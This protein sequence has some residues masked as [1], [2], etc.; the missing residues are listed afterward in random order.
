LDSEIAKTGEVTVEGHVLGRLEGFRFVADPAAGGS[1]AKA[2][3]AAA[4]KA[5]AGEMDARANRLSQAGDDQFIL[6]SDGLI[7]WQGDAVGALAAGEEILR[8]RVRILA[9]EQ[10]TGASRDAVQARLDLW[11]KAHIEK[12]LGPLLALTAAEDITGIARGVAFQLVEALGVLERQKVAEDVKGLDQPAR[13]TLRKYGVR[14]GAY[15]IY[16]PALLKPA[17]RALAVQLYALKQADGETNG[18]GEV[19]QLASSGRTSIA[20]NKEISGPLYRPAGYRVCGE[21][22]VRVD[23]L[24]RLADLIRPALAWRE[25]APG[26]KPAGAIDGFGFT[27]SVGMTSLVGSSG[28]DFA[29]ILR[30]LGY[31]MDRRPKPAEAASAAAAADGGAAADATAGAPAAAPAVGEAPSVA[32]DAGAAPSVAPDNGAAASA[33]IAPAEAAAIMGL[34]AEDAPATVPDEAAEPV[35]AATVEVSAAEASAAE[36]DASIAEGDN[37]PVAA[38]AASP[39][40]PTATPTTADREPEF[41][42]VWR[43]GRVDGRD[44]P[45]K[46]SARRARASVP[47]PAATAAATAPTDAPASA[48]PSEPAPKPERKSFGRHRRP[49]RRD[50]RPD[51][52]DARPDR[53]AERRARPEQREKQPDP[54]S[55]FAK[56]AALKAELEAKDR[57]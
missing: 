57:R 23:I 13:A 40:E 53:S 14:F 1:E 7:R 22:A 36:G 54:N 18:L 48:A 56:L 2:L 34:T 46:R 47:Q 21:R 20:V 5:L 33:D 50:N 41:I 4:Q 25:G 31:R 26:V 51:R 43:P 32:P 35:A 42:E 10:L 52:R 19:Q 11:I 8:P 29:S 6:V 17:P 44:R 28:E 55:P 45:R 37:V 15:H 30:A 16:I 24:E 9:D 38:Q 27:V 12:L 3:Q 49:D 39:S